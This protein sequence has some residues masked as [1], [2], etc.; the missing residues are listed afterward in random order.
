MNAIAYT[1][2]VYVYDQKHNIL[3]GHLFQDR[4]VCLV[5]NEGSF[6][7]HGQTV[8]GLGEAPA[9]TGSRWVVLSMGSSP[10]AMGSEEQSQDQPTLHS[11][12]CGGDFFVV[13]I[14]VAWND[15]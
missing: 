4:A 10:P 7:P 1:D 3:Q 13:K 8:A 9:G 2:L 5:Q 12:E 14:A 11:A 6:W 15:T